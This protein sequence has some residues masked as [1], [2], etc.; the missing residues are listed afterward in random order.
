VSSSHGRKTKLEQVVHL[1]CFLFVAVDDQVPVEELFLVSNIEA[2]A[3]GSASAVE[4]R[5]TQR[6]TYDTILSSTLRTVVNL[7]IKFVPARTLL[8]KNYRQP[9][10]FVRARQKIER[11]LSRQEN[12]QQTSSMIS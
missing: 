8:K 7:D 6:K 2:V 4:K 3:S 1:R 5:R 10:S 9:E 12:F 11:K